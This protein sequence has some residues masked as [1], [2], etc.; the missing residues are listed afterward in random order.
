MAVLVAKQIG[1][2][3]TLGVAS[4]SGH[5]SLGDAAGLP[6]FRVV[7]R[8]V[9]LGGASVGQQKLET[10]DNGQLFQSLPKLVIATGDAWERSQDIQHLADRDYAGNHI[11]LHGCLRMRAV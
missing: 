10:P 11:R 8:T 1:I 6:R 4:L 5:H 3:G 9:P 7:G 2:D